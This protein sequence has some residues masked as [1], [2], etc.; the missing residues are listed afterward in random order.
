MQVEETVDPN[1]ASVEAAEKAELEL[2]F[3]RGEV[4]S[5]EYLAQSGAVKNYLEAQG[6]PLDELRD[7]L[8]EDRHREYEGSWATATTEFLQSGNDWPGG[9]RNKQILGMKIQ[10][11]GLLNA[12]DKTAALNQA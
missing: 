9:E 11:L 5:D 1:R 4:S 10:E 7:R 8:Q 3:K 12:E 2:K 6:V